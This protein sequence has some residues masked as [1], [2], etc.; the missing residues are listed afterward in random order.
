MDID[1]R[2][3]TPEMPERVHEVEEVTQ[4]VMSTVSPE[5]RPAVTTTHRLPLVLGIFALVILLGG[6]VMAAVMFGGGIA[7]IMGIAYAM[8]LLLAASPVWGASLLRNQEEQY[9]EK[10]AERIVRWRHSH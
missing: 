8:V 5:G 1:V 2:S 4:G 6:T 7:V 10:R 3:G 9:A